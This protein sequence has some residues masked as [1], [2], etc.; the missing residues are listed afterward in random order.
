MKKIILLITCLLLTGC[1]N[2]NEIEKTAIIDAI[3]IDYENNLYEVTFEVIKNNDLDTLNLKA[4]YESGSG[5]NLIEAF[6]N[7][8]KKLDNNPLFSHLSLIIINDEII[9][10]HFDDIRDFILRNP[11][12]NNNIYLMGSFNKASDI[13]KNDSLNEITSDAIKGLINNQYNNYVN[14]L[15]FNKIVN[16]DISNGILSV[17]NYLDVN[18]HAYCFNGFGIIK[19]NHHFNSDDT[20]VYN[21]LTNNVTNIVI[22]NNDDIIRINKANTKYDFKNHEINIKLDIEL[23]S[24]KNDFNLKT[25][26]N[27]ITSKITQFYENIKKDNLDILGINQKYYQRYGKKKDYFKNEAFNINVKLTVL[28]NGLIYEVK[29]ET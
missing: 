29:N 20:K 7:V 9:K 2:Y 19:N 5:S 26:N 23:A 21:I 25:F 27:L 10:Y 14:N 13:L 24:I 3:S 22:S 12:I 6:Y 15:S 17:I 4:I 1:Y 18:N 8:E 11:K 16:D 28:K